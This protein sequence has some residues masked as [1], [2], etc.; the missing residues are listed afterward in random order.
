MPAVAGQW[1]ENPEVIAFASTLDE[2]EELVYDHHDLRELY[3]R[4][5]RAWRDAEDRGDGAGKVAADRQFDRVVALA[6]EYRGRP[7]SEQQGA[8][9]RLLGKHPPEEGPRE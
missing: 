8:T 2:F 6:G 7:Y 5:R 1:H 9:I 4:A 3:L